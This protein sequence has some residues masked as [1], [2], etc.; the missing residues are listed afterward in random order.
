MILSSLLPVRIRHSSVRPRL[1]RLPRTLNIDRHRTM[2]PTLANSAAQRRYRQTAKRRTDGLRPF[3]AVFVWK[4]RRSQRVIMWFCGSAGAAVRAK[5]PY[6]C[7]TPLALTTHIQSTK[8]IYR[9]QTGMFSGTSGCDSHTK[10]LARSALLLLLLS[11]TQGY[12]ANAAHR[13]ARLS[14]MKRQLSGPIICGMTE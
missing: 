9:G 1:P 5:L 10:A 11:A 6:L 14:G 8:C 12:A 7:R 2:C 13:T 4:E 3:L